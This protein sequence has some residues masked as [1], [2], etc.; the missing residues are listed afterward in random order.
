MILASTSGSGGPK[1]RENS[2]TTGSHPA[3]RLRG[4][5][6]AARA[7]ASHASCC[8]TSRAFT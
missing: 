5:S 2:P 8:R 6:L 7:R 1:Y 3:A 4:A